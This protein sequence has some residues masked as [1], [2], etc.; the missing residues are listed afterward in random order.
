MSDAVQRATQ[1]RLNDAGR[2][3]RHIL[4]RPIEPVMYILDDVRLGKVVK[5]RA[6]Y[7]SLFEV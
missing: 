2:V 6:V 3:M 4:Q 5:R 1:S 7:A